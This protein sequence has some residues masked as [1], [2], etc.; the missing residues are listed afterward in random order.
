MTANTS[1]DQKKWAPAMNRAARRAAG[2]RGPAECKHSK[3]MPQYDSVAAKLMTSNQIRT[4]FPR[5]SGI[6][7]DCG[8]QGILYASMEHY[9][10]GDW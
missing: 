2:E 10:A 4:T 1:P 6:C 8:Y 3:V 9:I 5:F 7:P